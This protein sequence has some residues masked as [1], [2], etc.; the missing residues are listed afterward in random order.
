VL[1]GAFLLLGL[2]WAGLVRHGRRA[3]ARAAVSEQL[4]LEDPLTG[5]GNRR[6]FELALAA[7]LAAPSSDAVVLLLDLDGF[8][9]INDT[10]GHDVGDEVLKTVAERLLATVRGTDVVA[11]LGGDEFVVLARPVAHAEVLRARLGEAV[12]QPLHVR[13][14]QLQPASSIGLAPVVPGQD[15]SEVLRAADRDL[16]ASKRE[17]GSVT[18]LGD[19]RAAR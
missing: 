6:A 9:G 5:L 1:I 7:E 4:A 19:R 10:W 11:R 14:G 17:R 18:L 8:K 15:Q 3:T 13:G 16:Y 2:C 12:A